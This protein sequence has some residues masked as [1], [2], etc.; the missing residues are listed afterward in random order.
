MHTQSKRTSVDLIIQLPSFPFNFLPTPKV[1]R[2]GIKHRFGV[3]NR[4][5][6]S[7]IVPPLPVEFGA[8]GVCLNVCCVC[9]LGLHGYKSE[10]KKSLLIL[11]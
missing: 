2:N 9:G 1:N 11:I 4:S 6:R 5:K 3:P 7:L 10:F 8:L